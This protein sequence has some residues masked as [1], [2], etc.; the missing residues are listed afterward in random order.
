MTLA[1]AWETEHM[2]LES[3]G[4]NSEEMVRKENSVGITP[5]LTGAPAGIQT[6]NQQIMSTN[7]RFAY[8]N[9]LRNYK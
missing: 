9:D 1:V 5:W 7:R 3:R 2:R 6:L 4:I 8:R